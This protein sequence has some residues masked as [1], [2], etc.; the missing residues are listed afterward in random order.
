MALLALATR[1]GLR[2]L[3]SGVNPACTGDVQQFL[4]PASAVSTSLPPPLQMP[5]VRA[6]AQGAHLRFFA[7]A[8]AQRE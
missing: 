2:R 1:T 5:E 8:A 4:L 7:E 6:L 3:V